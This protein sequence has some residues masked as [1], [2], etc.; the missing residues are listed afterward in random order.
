MQV[1]YRPISSVA[2]NVLFTCVLNVFAGARIPTVL[3]CMDNVRMDQSS[4]TIIRNLV[5]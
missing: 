3:F 4:Y 5:W 2:Y 1:M